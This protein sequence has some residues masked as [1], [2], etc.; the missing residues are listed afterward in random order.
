M[1]LCGNSALLWPKCEVNTGLIFFL[2]LSVIC[3][4]A[5]KQDYGLCWA[6]GAN[7]CAA[8]LPQ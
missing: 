8:M 3:F 4:L 2:C 6:L 5:L 1:T 7:C